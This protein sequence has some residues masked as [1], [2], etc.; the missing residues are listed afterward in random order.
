MRQKL[1]RGYRENVFSGHS[2]E[3]A[4]M[5]SQHVQDLRKL[6]TDKILSMKNR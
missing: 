6:K 5:S 2:S 4:H 1:L 3:V